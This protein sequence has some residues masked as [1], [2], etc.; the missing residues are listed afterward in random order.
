MDVYVGDIEDR[1]ER[2][3]AS[4]KLSGLHTVERREP[5]V[6]LVTLQLWLEH[7]PVFLLQYDCRTVLSYIHCRTIYAGRRKRF[8][9]ALENS[10]AS[11][12]MGTSY[13][14]VSE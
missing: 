7:H 9:N 8:E 6:A 12:I 4:S 1:F 14:R 11:G 5:L 10:V 3:V 13:L 2:P